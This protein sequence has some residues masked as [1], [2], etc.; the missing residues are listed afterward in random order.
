MRRPLVKLGLHEQKTAGDKRGENN[1]KHNAADISNSQSNHKKKKGVKI[2]IKM[3]TTKI[4]P[5]FS[6]LKS[7]ASKKNPLPRTPNNTK[8][9]LLLT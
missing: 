5:S 2:I 4:T 7:K 1:L 9:A 3:L 6:S 8:K